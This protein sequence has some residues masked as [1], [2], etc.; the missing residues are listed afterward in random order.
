VLAT[1]E[2]VS[3]VD[4]RIPCPIDLPEK[5]QPGFLAAIHPGGILS[6]RRYHSA[7]RKLWKICQGAKICRVRDY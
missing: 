6:A 1:G 3:E 2:I 5:D 7:R 4:L